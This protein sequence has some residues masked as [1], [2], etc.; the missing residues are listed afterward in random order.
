MVRSV[1][2]GMAL[3]RRGGYR[4][5]GGACACGGVA[6]RSASVERETAGT[7]RARAGRTVTN[8]PSQDGGPPRER[9]LVCSAVM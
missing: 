2:R 9:S 5:G 7:A 8:K 1:R 6:V 4:F 3:G